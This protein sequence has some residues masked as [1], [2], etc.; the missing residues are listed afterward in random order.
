[1]EISTA[2]IIQWHDAHF[3]ASWSSYLG[4]GSELKMLKSE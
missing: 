1:M 3:I 4:F 2:V